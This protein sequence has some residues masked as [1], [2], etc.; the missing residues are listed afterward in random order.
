MQ[1][2]LS[3]PFNIDTQNSYF[4][5]PTRRLMNVSL[6]RKNNAKKDLSIEEV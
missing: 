4:F 1:R 6:T 3:H 2:T 5:P